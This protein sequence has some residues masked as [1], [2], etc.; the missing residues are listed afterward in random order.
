MANPLY[1]RLQATADRL[2]KKYGQVGAIKRSVPPDPV[3]GGDAEPQTF[4]AKLVP[5]TYDQ[6][7]VNGTSILTTDRELYISSVGLGIVP[8][9]GDIATAGGVDYLIIAGDPNNYDGLTSVVF[10][11][12]GRIM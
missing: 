5:M 9:V 6:R 2:L 10:I 11:V 12:Q 8:Q 1:A 3:L 7:Y 4:P